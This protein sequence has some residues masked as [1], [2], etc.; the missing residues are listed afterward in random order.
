MLL[1]LAFVMAGKTTLLDVLAG[2]KRIGHV[3]GSIF[4]NGY[5]TTTKAFSR[6][7]GYVQQC[8]DQSP[9]YTVYEALSF[10]ARLRLSHK[11]GINKRKAFIDVVMSTLDLYKAKNRLIGRTAEDGLPLGDRKRLAIGVELVSN[12]SILFL[13][14]QTQSFKLVNRQVNDLCGL[15]NTTDE[16]ITGVDSRTAFAVMQ[17]VKKI[18]LAGRGI[19]VTMHQPSQRVMRL[20]DQLLLLKRGGQT[21]SGKRHQALVL[22]RVML[23][24]CFAFVGRHTLGPLVRAV[25]HLLVICQPRLVYRQSN[26]V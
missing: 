22:V 19:M 11:V 2:R 21:V 7:V 8:G 25:L 10:S 13:G 26:Q 15:C 18:A 14:E 16:P 4:V 3:T 24:L 6:V 12:P 23:S 17:S 1:S 20:F 5:P 9:Y